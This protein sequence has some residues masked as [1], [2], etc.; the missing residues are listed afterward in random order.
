MLVLARTTGSPPRCYTISI[1]AE[2]DLRVPNLDILAVHA[3][4]RDCASGV[5][6]GGVTLERVRESRSAIERQSSTESTRQ[7]WTE[8]FAGPV[9]TRPDLRLGH[10]QDMRDLTHAPPFEPLKREG[11]VIALRD[12]RP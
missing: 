11:I 12:L 8:P 5:Q 6:L 9:V 7:Q 3:R 4:V 1:I 2:L 10:P